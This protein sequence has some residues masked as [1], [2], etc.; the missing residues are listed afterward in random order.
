MRR[1][2]FVYELAV[3]YPLHLMNRYHPIGVATW[4]LIL[5]DATKGVPNDGQPSMVQE[6]A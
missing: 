6:G 1:L 2:A 3:D 4:T 5:L